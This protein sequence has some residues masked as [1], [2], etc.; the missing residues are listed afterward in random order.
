MGT[1]PVWN[2]EAWR[3]ACNGAADVQAST[4][5]CGLCNCLQCGDAG[6]GCSTTY[7]GPYHT[8]AAIAA[9]AAAGD[10]CEAGDL[11]RAVD[12]LDPGSMRWLRKTCDGVVHEGTEN[13]CNGV[14]VDASNYAAD[15]SPAC[16]RKYDV[17]AE[18]MSD[19]DD[20]VP[21]GNTC[22][23]G[24]DYSDR[25]GEESPY[26]T[27]TFLC[28]GDGP[29]GGFEEL[30]SARSTI[31]AALFASVTADVCSWDTLDKRIRELPDTNYFVWSADYSG[32]EGK[33]NPC[34][35]L[36]PDTAAEPIYVCETRG[37]DNEHWE[38]MGQHTDSPSYAYNTSWKCD[39]DY[40]IGWSRTA[41][42][43]DIRNF[44]TDKKR[45]EAQVTV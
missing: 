9:K 40:A 21:V 8:T 37:W 24:G 13:E 32:E 41:I 2:E 31:A 7:T 22:A 30:Y 28:T 1:D 33:P 10:K 44:T 15:G 14:Y 20:T 5:K 29:L 19:I 45:Y 11:M 34:P 23:L 6:K 27:T 4:E 36:L 17:Q 12:A 39:M 38:D 26:K 42:Q 43:Y 18:T 16:L 35:V 25:S 3:E